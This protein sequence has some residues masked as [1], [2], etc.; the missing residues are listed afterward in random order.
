MIIMS[1]LVAMGLIAAYGAG[2]TLVIWLLTKLSSTKLE[3]LLANREIGYLPASFSIADAWVWAPALFLSSKMA[4]TQGWVG[5]FWF[6]VPNITC[7]I[8]FAFFAVKLRSTLPAGYTFAG[9]MR[10]KHSP[11]VQAL[12]VLAHGGL[13]ACSFAVQLLAG[14]TFIS[15]ISGAPFPIVTIELALVAVGYSLLR[16]MRGS[17]MSDYVQLSLVFL[18]GIAVIPWT[19]YEGG[20]LETV[21]RGVN[22]VSGTYTSLWSGDGFDVFLTFGLSATIGLTTGPFGDQSFYQRAFATS[23]EKVRAAFLTAPWIFAVVPL[24]MAPLGFL[25]AGMH[26]PIPKGGDPLY[27]NMI[28]VINLLPQGAIAFMF[29]L[30]AGLVSKLDTNLSSISSLA[31]YDAAGRDSSDRRSLMFS[32]VSMALLVIGGLG[33]ANIPG[34]KLVHLFLIYGTLRSATFIPTVLS[35][36]WEKV[37]EA[38]VFYGIIIS[39]VVGLPMFGYGLLTNTLWLSIS[40]TLFAVLASGVITLGATAFRK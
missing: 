2:L 15:A 22:G 3:Y 28:T 30:L 32:R 17:V 9:Y 37:S 23:K 16:G 11:R 25:A 20:G 13:G 1:P 24:G 5:L 40:G 7:L 12:Y 14:A 10:E 36:L 29:L 6:T 39:V 8:L 34:L 4:Y 27:I 38:G 19:V 26:M 18:I 21:W 31:G 35:V 33:I